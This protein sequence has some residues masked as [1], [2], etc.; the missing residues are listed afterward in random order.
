[1]K[2]HDFDF[3][4]LSMLHKHLKNTDM[5]KLIL[6]LAFAGS[7]M[8]AVSACNSTKNVSGS[9]DSTLT[10]TTMKPIDTAR[11]DTTKKMPMDTT[12]SKPPM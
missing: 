8:M 7:L 10:D 3:N 9:A 5:K 6:S 12:Q 2:R 1:M 11:M 4:Q